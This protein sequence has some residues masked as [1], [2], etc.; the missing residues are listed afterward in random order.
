[1]FGC[2][3]KAKLPYSF[4]KQLVS[5]S[6]AG[7]LG[8]LHVFIVLYKGWRL[9]TCCYWV[10]TCTTC[11]VYNTVVDRV[12][13]MLIDHSDHSEGRASNPH[14]HVLVKHQRCPYQIYVN[15]KLIKINFIGIE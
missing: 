15:K 8:G 2:R 5:V 7:V 12:F 4:R 13:E 1:V 11:Y 3:D 9:S 14:C 10:Q 6:E